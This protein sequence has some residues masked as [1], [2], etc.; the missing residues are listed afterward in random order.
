MKQQPTSESQRD[1]IVAW[2]EQDDNF[3]RVTAFSAPSSPYSRLGEP[4]VDKAEL[5][6]ANALNELATSVN[7]A[8]PRSH[9]DVKVT[10]EMLQHYLTE[11]KTTAKVA[12]TPGFTLTKTDQLLGIKSIEDKLNSMCR[13]FVRLQM[14]HDPRIRAARTGSASMHHNK[15]MVLR[16]DV[17]AVVEAAPIQER[18]KAMPRPDTRQMNEKSALSKAQEKVIPLEH[19]PRQDKK[20]DETSGEKGRHAKAGN[21]VSS[22]VRSAAAMNKHKEVTGSAA[23]LEEPT[24][25]IP[26]KNGKKR[27][28]SAKHKHQQQ[29]KKKEEEEEHAKNVVPVHEVIVLTS[30]E[31]GGGK[32]LPSVQSKSVVTVQRR[33]TR[34]ASKASRNVAEDF[35]WLKRKLRR[36]EESPEKTS[37]AEGYRTPPRTRRNPGSDKPR[38]PTT[39]SHTSTP[40]LV[41]KSPGKEQE[42]EP[43][44]K[45]AEPASV[46]TACEEAPVQQSA[47]I[48]NVPMQDEMSPASGQES[49]K[50]ISRVLN[51]TPAATNPAS[52]QLLLH[53]AETQSTDSPEGTEQASSTTPTAV[54]VPIAPPSVVQTPSAP[55]SIADASELHVQPAKTTPTQPRYQ[56]SDALRSAIAQV[57]S[58]RQE[59]LNSQL[60]RRQI[61]FSDSDYAPS[62]EEEEFSMTHYTPSKG[63]RRQV[64]NALAAPNERCP[65][66]TGDNSTSQKPVATSCSAVPLNIQDTSARTPSAPSGL[67]NGIRKELAGTLMAGQIP[68]L[69]NNAQTMDGPTN[70]DRK[71]AFLRAKQLAFEQFKWTRESELQQQEVE[72]LRREMEIRESFALKEIKLKRMN[73]RAEII[74]RMVLSGASPEDISERL[75]LL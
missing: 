11:F 57:V 24:Q 18:E 59:L 53:N 14:L 22:R 3:L 8:S 68:T 60:S 38:T 62:E 30:A 55:Q 74:Q 5:V 26:P 54:Q 28:V 13:H 35:P 63:R 10:K 40:H 75:A 31:E 61:D 16:S 29:Q 1:A 56:A 32:G 7:C 37:R 48:A 21:G 43:A 73:I 66:F 12:S 23:T 65:Q 52:E 45:P 6:E 71:R 72:L 27:A 50:S 47:S 67:S 41:Q 46:T 19:E 25:R 34:S 42:S 2:L 15:E 17:R 69:L 58:Q 20:V 51:P 39:N 64:N 44:S 70:L 36:V 4:N 33:L 49:A 9:W